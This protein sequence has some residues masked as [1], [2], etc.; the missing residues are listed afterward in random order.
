MSS[1]FGI[2]AGGQSGFY[3]FEITNGLR[4]NGSNAY[5]DK[6][7]SS[8]SNRQTWTFSAWV[9]RSTLGTQQFIWAATASSTDRS[10]IYFETDNT[11]RIYLRETNV[12]M[13]RGSGVSIGQVSSAVFRDT[14]AWYH[15]VVAMDTTQA[16]ASSPLRADANRLKFYVNS[17]QQTNDTSHTFANSAILQNVNTAYNKENIDHTLGIQGYDDASDFGGYMAEVNFID[18]LQLTPT[19]FGQLK[20]GVWVPKDTSGLT[21]GTNGFRLQFKQNG[22]GTASSS[23][24]GADTSGQ[25]NHYTSHNL[26]AEDVTIDSPTNNFAT[27]SPYIDA[28]TYGQQSDPTP[29]DGNLA[30]AMPGGTNNIAVSTFELVPPNKYRA[31]FTLTS[32][33]SSTNFEFGCG[34]TNKEI[35]AASVRFNSSGYIAVD[36]STVQSSLTSANTVGD[37]VEV[38]VDLENDTVKF[39]LLE[40]GSS[41]WAS[42]GTAQAISAN[43]TNPII[44]VREQGSSNINGTFDFG[45]LGY[46]GSDDST[47]SPMSTANLPE[48]TFS[49]KDDDIPEDYFQA[50]IWT[51]NGTSQ[52]IS[53]YEFSPDWVWIKERSSTSSHMVYD[54][55]RG[56]DVFIQTNSTVANTS[57]TVNLTSFDSNGFSLGDGGSTNQSSQTYVGWAWLA[58]GTPTATNS[59]AAG[60]APTSGSVMINGSA[61]TASLAGT[62][63]AKKI[64]ANTEAGFSIVQYEG[65]GSNATIAHALSSAP[66]WVIHKRIETDGTNWAIFHT[67]IA[68][69]KHMVLNTTAKETTSTSMFNSTSPTSTVI[70]VGTSSHTNSSSKDYIAYCFHSVKG[71]SRFGSYTGNGSGSGIVVYTG[72]RPAFVIVKRSS[73][74]SDAS[75]WFLADNARSP[76][77]LVDE[78][79]AANTSQEENDSSLIGA[80]GA[81]DFDFLANGFKLRASNAGTN[82]DGQTYIYMAFAEIPFKYANA[83]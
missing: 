38:L 65:T 69:T 67:S 68:N 79:L 24:I 63:A 80:S 11:L 14:S 62:I 72:F 10:M 50:N 33:G 13:G 52:S 1:L 59:E 82:S 3:G 48:P 74:T 75:G 56:T 64:S 76:L 21:F 5:L 66:E 77:N 15:I 7:P 61:S 36:G 12:N 9:K 35:G 39:A 18:G 2:A 34:S 16:D 57:S 58:G 25:T 28:G 44:W 43:V 78:K 53:T 20:S 73:G 29:T 55:I 26:D 54:T 6:T 60:A 22:T 41:T 70:S 19:S 30:I 71:Y 8:T 81:N 23:T 40:N 32:R 46:S 27:L 17:V 31:K 47:Y 37:A 49:P 4:F 45:Q 51:G 42:L 83:R